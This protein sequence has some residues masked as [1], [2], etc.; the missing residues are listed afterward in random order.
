SPALP[1][2]TTRPRDDHSTPPRWRAPPT[3]QANGVAERSPIEPEH[4]RARPPADPAHTAPSPPGRPP[5]LQPRPHA[6]HHRDRAACPPRAHRE[7]SPSLCGRGTHPP[8]AQRKEPPMHRTITAKALALV[9]G[10]IASVG[11]V[12]VPAGS[13]S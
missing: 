13:A 7:I 8:T 5:T 3:S 4:R 10:P 11:L 6:R 9:L 12:S 1:H 2:P